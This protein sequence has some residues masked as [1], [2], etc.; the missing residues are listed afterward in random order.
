HLLGRRDD[1]ERGTSSYGN[2]T[3]REGTVDGSSVHSRRTLDADESTVGPRSAAVTLVAPESG[4]ARA[5]LIT[6]SDYEKGARSSW[7]T[8]SYRV[9]ISPKFYRFQ[10][11][12]PSSPSSFWLGWRSSLSLVHAACSSRQR[13]HRRS[14]Y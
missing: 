8:P 5:P 10:A 11:Q 6:A 2:A 12:A 4:G 7:K 14:H 13:G 9:S 3:A 1:R